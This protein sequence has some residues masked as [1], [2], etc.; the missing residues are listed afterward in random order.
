MTLCEQKIDTTSLL[1]GGCSRILGVH[2]LNTGLFRHK[3]RGRG[4]TRDAWENVKYHV[5]NH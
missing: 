4:I 3:T 2:G 1:E 5:V